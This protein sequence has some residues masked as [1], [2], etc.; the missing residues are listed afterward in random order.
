MEKDKMK[1]I[2]AALLV[3]HFCSL[4][5]V[6]M[7]DSVTEHQIVGEEFLV[8][9]GASNI[10][11][12]SGNGAVV[13]VSAGETVVLNGDFEGN[14][15]TAGGGGV[16][17][18]DGG[19][20]FVTENSS[21]KGNVADNK[22][23]SNY[24]SPHGGVIQAMSDTYV[25]I[26]DSVLFYG[27]SSS[28]TGGAIYMETSDTVSDSNNILLVGDYVQFTSNTAA[29][30]AG[31]VYIG[32]RNAAFG[33]NVSFTGNKA[34][35]QNGGAL[36]VGSFWNNVTV[37]FD[38]GASF[39]N[40]YA[41][42]EGGA[43]HSY[44]SNG[45]SQ[46]IT[47]D[48][49]TFESNKAGQY[50][51]AIYN[52]AAENSESEIEIGA[53]SF[54]TSNEAGNDGG[55]IYN[56]G[57]GEITIEGDTQFSSNTAGQNGGAIYN[58]GKGEITIE[59]DTQFS[60]N[61]AGQNGGAIYNEGSITLDTTAG[62]I[63]FSGNTANG[64]SNDIYLY[65]S[66]TLTLQDDTIDG[67]T[68]EV[69]IGSG[70]AG[71]VGTLITN[72]GTTLVL[73]SGS[74]NSSYLGTYTQNSGTTEVNSEFF[75]GTST[76]AGG[77]LKLNNGAEIV[78]GSKLNVEDEVTANISGTVEINGTTNNKGT[79]VIEEEAK[80]IINSTFN[81]EG[82]TTIA[83]AAS[84]IVNG[85]LD[86]TDDSTITNN[87]SLSAVGVYAE[88][89]LND[90]YSQTTT[91]SL[92]ISDGAVLDLL[93]GSLTIE[94]GS[95]TFTE[96]GGLADG[97]TL[98]VTSNVILDIGNDVTIYSSGLGV[99][100]GYITIQ[101]DQSFY[102]D[103][104]NY[105]VDGDTLCLDVIIANADI[106]AKTFET[107]L[108]IGC[109]DTC[110]TTLTLSDNATT[111]AGLVV[112]EDSTLKLAPTADGTLT[113]KSDNS[114]TGSGTVLVDEI[115]RTV[116]YDYNGE[117]IEEHYGVGTIEIYSDNR[118][119]GGT[120]QQNMGT[121]IVE[122]GAKFFGGENTVSGGSLTIK[123]GGV[124]VGEN[125]ID[126]G[127][128][129]LNDGAILADSDNCSVSVTTS[130]SGTYG[131]VNIY[132][133]IQG[134]VEE[135]EFDGKT[136]ISDYLIESGDLTYINSNDS[137]LGITING[138][139]L[140]L[141]NNTI[142]V[143]DSEDGCDGTL[144]LGNTDDDAAVGVYHLTLGN[145]SGVEASEIKLE[146]NTSLTYK[147][148]AY[149]KEDSTVN[150]DDSKNTSL[151][152]ANEETDIEY[153]PTIISKSASSSINKSGAGTT[154]IESSLE[155][156]KGSVNVTGGSLYLDG[157]DSS[158]DLYLSG[159][160]VENGS[161]TTDAYINVYDYTEES[162]NYGNV[163]VN[164]G[165]LTINNSLNVAN[166]ITFVSSDVSIDGDL[167]GDNITSNAAN[168]TVEGDVD[169]EKSLTISNGSNFTVNGDVTGGE[170][171]NLAISGS[172]TV[173]TLNGDE[174]YVGDD[175]TLTDSTLN[176]FTNMTV[177]GDM[178]IESSSSG[179]YIPTINMQDGGINTIT[180][181]GKLTQSSDF[182]MSFDY[183]PRGDA[184]DQIIVNDA[185]VSSQIIITGI[186]FINSPDNY[187]FTINGSELIVSAD[188]G[189][190]YANIG[191]SQFYANAALGQYLITATSSDSTIKGSLQYINPQMYRAQVVTVAQYANQLSFNNLLFDHAAI[192]SGQF[193]SGS[194]DEIA[195]RYAAANPL[196]G[197]YQ[198]SKKDGGVWFK[199]Y[200]NIE[201][202]SMT[203][204]LHVDNT[205]YGA[206]VGADLPVVE[207]KQGWKLIP[208]AYVAY[209]GA[210][211][212]YDFVSMYQNGGQIGAMATAYKGDFFTSLLAY[213]GGYANEMNVRDMGYGAT[214]LAD[215]TGNWFAGVASKSAYNVRLPKDF[216]I[217]PTAMIAYNIFG[218]QNY[219]STFGGNL[220]MS[221]GFLN[222]INLAPGVNVI[223]NKKTFSIYGT[224]QMVF[225]IMGGVDGYAG[226]VTLD[227]VRIK[228]PYIEYGLGVVKSFKDR[229]SGYFQFTIRNGGRTG[230][231]FMGGIQ[232]KLG[233]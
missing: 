229:F 94:S 62:D 205:A 135:G 78:A 52:W 226:R 10:E 182:N 79:T 183:D 142:I 3:L 11:Y 147:D 149:I 41:A 206:I 22:D 120:Y 39:S 32:D 70:I 154:I 202:I 40:N 8:I 117:P 179:S 27:N 158:A 161:L 106:S 129:N 102:F 215:N 74:V 81:N 209:N 131:T 42:L 50:G 233:K 77:T 89:V 9:D 38:E 115:V 198:Y 43:L 167:A 219:G 109:N 160:S 228:H 231:G 122:S 133:P 61:T 76:I 17:S 44:V 82:A 180:V 143:A 57:K 5:A 49:V 191:D 83:E 178:T 214:T 132:N 88:I 64:N 85:K 217:Q 190:S 195:N 68:N 93:D 187:T 138:G 87:G 63:S 108:T 156:F 67:S 172:D 96:G 159:I 97:D 218:N 208:T 221:S 126:G 227:D 92:T 207:L 25:S 171:S 201:N 232:F 139:G 29:M 144:T 173:V 186:N 177:G 176:N 31:A 95:I 136:I 220:G 20:I 53:G 16:V 4:P 128:L 151:N 145:G 98:T 21:F 127:T 112:S 121:V 188:G 192:V 46:S 65:N 15:T 134:D 51:G 35:T 84:V 12:D 19:S 193:G 103:G 37:T 1:R 75:G 199:A 104:G 110:D 200:G 101:E 222:G 111:D 163:S 86:S 230:I 113:L 119:F 137:T 125:T 66:G 33:K 175:F 59:G 58:S 196:F 90:N 153:T 28:F 197:P 69:S 2:I 14:K 204:G 24:P 210:H 99:G 141:F 18:S 224:A 212:N 80:V 150:M 73:E 23:E 71:A 100:G 123:S 105:T 194:D 107:N 185:C 48:S 162:G 146:D 211:Q 56:S 30:S 54:F 157:D 26:G 165:S 55:A 13:E 116:G 140:G 225:N 47:F 203:K 45:K 155:D 34:T 189:S 164:N 168:V 36:M 184:M 169:F 166:N 118:N 223:W 7:A 72:N 124:L 6:V 91:G 148:Y 170:D 114:V 216:I 181:D 152:F 60:S 213:G 130:D 174:T